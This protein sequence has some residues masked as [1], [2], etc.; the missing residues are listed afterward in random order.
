MKDEVRSDGRVEEGLRM[1][2][3]GS[4]SEGRGS[5]ERRS[6]TRV[7]EGEEVSD[8]CGGYGDVH[9]DLSLVFR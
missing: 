6:W 5:I 8:E 4:E 9:G 2:V 7:K 1:G 3:D